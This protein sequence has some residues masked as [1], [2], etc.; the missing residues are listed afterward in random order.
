MSA[1]GTTEEQMKE[2]VAQ[3][4]GT[5]I[6]LSL[7][8]NWEDVDYKELNLEFDKLTGEDI[9]SLEG[10]FLALNQGKNFLPAFKNEHPAYLAVLAAKAAG[11]HPNFLKK[12]P[13]KDFNRVIGAS[14]RFLDGLI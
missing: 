10:D 11:V 4:T 13:A 14:R 1:Q 2:E 3:P 8:V 5:V 9:I 6:R 7:S 12:L